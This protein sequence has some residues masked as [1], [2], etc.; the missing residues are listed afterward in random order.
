[1]FFFFDGSAVMKDIYFDPVV[2]KPSLKRKLIY[3]FTHSLTVLSPSL[4][5]SFSKKLL[6]N[7]Y[8]RR[9]YQ[10]RT[11]VQ[12]ITRLIDTRY[13]ALCLH[14]FASA[15]SDLN[16]NILLCHG[17][18]D[19]STRFTQL[20]DALIEQGYRVWSIDQIGHGQS[21]GSYA[22][23][24]RFLEGITTAVKY[25][26]DNGAKNAA[27]LGHSKGALAVLNLPE[28]ILATRKVILISAPAHFFENMFDAVESVG[29]S[30]LMLQNF[31]KQAS[32]EYGTSWQGMAIENN[33]DKVTRDF[34]F[35]HDIEDNICPYTELEALLNPLPADIYTTTGLGHI[36]LLKYQPLLDK[37]ASFAKDHPQHE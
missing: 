30:K 32:I 9:K 14:E 23:L 25:L 26:D 13:G 4:S 21:Y 28:T 5:V 29:V 1:M 6:G 11:Q 37:I 10:M 15:Q 18:G 3:W 22:D 34:L 31:L 20:I 16:R 24:Y 33:L 2:G 27:V 7:P 36:K 12:P 8:S 35:I 17:W 19:S